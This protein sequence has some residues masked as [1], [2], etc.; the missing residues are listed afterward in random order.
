VK[1]FL[2]CPVRNS[3][4]EDY[5]EVVNQIEALG[6]TLHFP[7]RDTEQHDHTGS[8]YRICEEN[9]AAIEASDVIFVVWDGESQGSLFDLGMAFALRKRVIGLDLPES[10]G[11]KSFQ[12]MIRFMEEKQKD[13]DEES[14]EAAYNQIG[15]PFD[16][17]RFYEILGDY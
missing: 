7:L 13:Q 10:S 14:F 4:A 16:L 15:D 9:R 5:E 12:N 3:E 1:A 11:G 17:K 6:F 2:I 8:G